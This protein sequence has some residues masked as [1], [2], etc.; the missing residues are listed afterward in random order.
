MNDFDAR[1]AFIS[2]A[3]LGASIA[4]ILGLRGLTKPET[5]RSGMRL[6]AGGMVL[7]ICGTLVNHELVSYQWILIGL[8]VGSLLGWPLGQKVAMTQ[9][10][11]RIAISHLFGALA[12]RSRRVRPSVVTG[13]SSTVEVSSCARTRRWIRTFRTRGRFSLETVTSIGDV[14]PC[15]G[16]RP[17]RTAALVWLITAPLPHASAAA[18]SRVR[19][20][21]IGPIR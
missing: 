5:A 10:P 4:F 3:Y 14:A 1:T 8:V 13:M 15:G 21:V 12:A 9:M 17:Q 20:I 6:A 18:I 7:A 2:A 19:G 11:Q 16:N